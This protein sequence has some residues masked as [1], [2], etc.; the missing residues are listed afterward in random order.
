[1]NAIGEGVCDRVRLS[2]PGSC[3]SFLEIRKQ[4]TGT[5][6]SMAISRERLWRRRWKHMTN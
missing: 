4:L 1:M 3:E 6:M 2:G 5:K